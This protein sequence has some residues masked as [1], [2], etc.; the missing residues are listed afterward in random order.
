MKYEKIVCPTCKT[1][2][3][4]AELILAEAEKSVLKPL[5]LEFYDFGGGWTLVPMP[6]SGLQS[7]GTYLSS[8][9]VAV[10]DEKGTKKTGVKISYSDLSSEVLVS[11]LE[12]AVELRKTQQ[13]EFAIVP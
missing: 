13:E 6:D 2:T 11:S 10:S 5:G 1:V 9:M 4:N 12:K 7:N 3:T 8:H